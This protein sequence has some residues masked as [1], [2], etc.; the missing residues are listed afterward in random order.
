MLKTCIRRKRPLRLGH[1][2]WL[3]GKFFSQMGGGLVGKK[4]TSNIQTKQRKQIDNME[5]EEFQTL[6]EGI[7]N[8]SEVLLDLGCWMF[9]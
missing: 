1:G 3:P 7:M 5:T 4:T 9:P 2:G 8:H 6:F